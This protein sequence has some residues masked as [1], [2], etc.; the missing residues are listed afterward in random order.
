LIK[1]EYYHGGG[2]PRPSILNWF[3][4]K[5]ITGLLGSRQ[6]LLGFQKKP[7]IQLEEYLIFDDTSPSTLLEKFACKEVLGQKGL[8]P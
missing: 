2:H 8:P 7:K 5:L 1:R 4:R 6:V 3:T